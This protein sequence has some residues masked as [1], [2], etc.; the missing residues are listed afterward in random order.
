MV[1]QLI[2]W[3]VTYTFVLASSSRTYEKDPSQVPYFVI[4]GFQ[5]DCAVL[6]GL[7]PV[8]GSAIVRRSSQSPQGFGASL[9]VAH[10]ILAGIKL[11][12]RCSPQIY[13]CSWTYYREDRAILVLIHIS[14]YHVVIRAIIVTVGFVITHLSILYL[15]CVIAF[16]HRIYLFCRIL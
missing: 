5:F 7:V 11:F 10:P 15:P 9:A 1:F 12:T 14:I 2:C 3:W 4:N 13:H 8:C 6:C 16:I